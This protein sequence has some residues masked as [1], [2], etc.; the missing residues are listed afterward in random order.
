M[1]MAAAAVNFPKGKFYAL[2]W[3]IPDNYG[4]MTS[5]M[6]H[7]CRAFRRLGEVKVEVLT[8][9][10]RP[11]YAELSAKLLA[12]G[13]LTEGVSIRNLWDDLR[14]RNLKPAAKQKSPLNAAELLVPAPD[15][16]VIE[17]DGVV[18][19]RE[20]RDGH[21]AVVSSDRFRRDGS[22]LAT[23]RIDESGHTVMLYNAEGQPVRRWGSRWKL[24]RWW[25]DR[26]LKK[27]LS[28]LIIDSK[29][30]ARFVPGYR[31]EHVVTLPWCMPRTATPRVLSQSCERLVRRCCSDATTLT[32][33]S[34]SPSGSAKSWCMTLISSA[35][36]RAT[37]CA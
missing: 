28:Y 9:D 33:S 32:R 16:R 10:D 22:I 29:T 36:T 1:D 24:Y 7:R 17:H 13:E 4:G 18:L 31:R 27:R 20:R 34:C 8:L 5:A 15:D 30:A 11:D 23:E 2:T 25:L 12:S 14:R 19:L 3:S 37:S 35:S 6:L 26:V 21:G